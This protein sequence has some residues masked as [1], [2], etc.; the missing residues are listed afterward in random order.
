MVTLVEALRRGEA[1][2]A[3]HVFLACHFMPATEREKAMELLV[4]KI[5]FAKDSDELA[6]AAMGSLRLLSG[7]DIPVTDR[8]QWLV[9]WQ[10]HRKVDL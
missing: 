1:K 6:R 4:E 8:R 10:T 7:Q 5:R 3:R 9:W 2:Y